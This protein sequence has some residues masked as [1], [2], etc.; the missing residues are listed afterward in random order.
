MERLVPEFQ[1]VSG[2]RKMAQHLT[3]ERKRSTSFRILLAGVEA[4]ASELATGQNEDDT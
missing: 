1:K 2:A 3:R 4:V